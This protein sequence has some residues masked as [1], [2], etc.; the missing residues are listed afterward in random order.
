MR[1]TF[2]GSPT[3]EI[4]AKVDTLMTSLPA[5]QAKVATALAEQ[6]ELLDSRLNQA[7]SQLVQLQSLA[8]NVQSVRVV[9]DQVH[10]QLQDQISALGSTLQ[11]HGILLAEHGSELSEIAADQDVQD[12][13]LA[14]LVDSIA[15]A[16]T[17]ALRAVQVAEVLAARRV[18]IRVQA[19]EVPKLALGTV[20]DRP[21]TWAQPMPVASYDVRPPVVDPGILGKVTATIKPDSIT[22]AGCTVTFKA[23]A[24]ISGGTATIIGAALA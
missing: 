1:R 8:G 6:R 22:Q 3:A 9:A 10:Q 19:I 21:V 20:V 2:L 13:R 15:A 18:H 16:N 14:Q 5:D 11:Q 23:T 12:Q 24:A 17:T 7:G 4:A